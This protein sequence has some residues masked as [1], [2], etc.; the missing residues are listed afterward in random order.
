LLQTYKRC[1]WWMQS[2]TLVG[3]AFVLMALSSGEAPF[4]YFQF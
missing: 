4:V 1:P 2:A 3:A